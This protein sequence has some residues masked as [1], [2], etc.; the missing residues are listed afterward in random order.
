MNSKL[1]F[2]LWGLTAVLSVGVAIYAYA[3]LPLGGSPGP[4]VLANAFARPW[5]VIHVTG[6]GT[7]LLLVAFQLLPAI[8]R[9][10]AVHR[11]IGRIYASA[12]ILG[13]SAGLAVAVGTTAGPIAA[14]GFGLLAVIWIYV[15]AQG[16][17]TARA[18]RFDEHRRWMI[19]SFALTFAAVTLRIYMPLS[20]AMHLDMDQ[21]YRAIAWLAWV[22]NLV[23][24]ELYL[25]R[26]SL[27]LQPAE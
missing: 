26:G 16:W 17:L 13:G 24:A 11:W 5:L 25:R 1:S 10:R 22:P 18:R 14:T 27:R 19:R 12:C 6:A 4:A 3:V 21:A 2:G 7:A 8:R 9:R 15:T 23:C 20:M